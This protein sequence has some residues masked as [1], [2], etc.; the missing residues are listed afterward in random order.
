MEEHTPLQAR[1]F[2]FVYGN[3]SSF[4]QSLISLSVIAVKLLLANQCPALWLMTKSKGT[5][6]S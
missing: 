5:A 1:W 4:C 2:E 3:F 6:R